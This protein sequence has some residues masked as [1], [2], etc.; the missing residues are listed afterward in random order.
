MVQWSNWT[1]I[2]NKINFNLSLTLYTK[3]SSKW[4]IDLNIK[5]KTVRLFLKIGENL[6]DL[7]LGRVL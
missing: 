5:L 6:Q 1:S 3:S 4:I 2:G 7:G